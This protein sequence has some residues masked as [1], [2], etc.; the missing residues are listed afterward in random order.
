[1]FTLETRMSEALSQ[2]PELRQILPA[3]HPAFSRLSHPVL[4]K[5]LPRLVTVSDAARIAGVD[6]NAL[7]SVLNLPGASPAAAPVERTSSPAPPWLSWASPQVFDARPL[8]EAGEEPFAPIMTRFR[9]LRPGEVLVVLAGFDPAPLLRLMS[10]RG[11]RTHGTWEGEIFRAA[12][13]RPL[14]FGEVAAEVPSERLRKKDP[15]FVLDV[16]GLEPPEPLRLVLAT[17]ERPDALPLTVLHH[18]EPALLYPRLAERG[19]RWEVTARDDLVE[20]RID[21]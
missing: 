6:A 15:G 11:W 12:F 14:D 9:A 4:G 17:L 8:L 10:D 1:M 16:R 13:E 2:R 5:V 18:R 3:F 19:L 21:R 7:L 20:I